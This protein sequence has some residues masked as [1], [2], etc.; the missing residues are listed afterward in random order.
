MNAMAILAVVWAWAIG[1]LIVAVLWPR[2]RNLRGDA[3]LILPLGALLGLA[4]SSVIFFFASRVFAAPGLVAGVAEAVLAVI[5]ALRL[6]RREPVMPAPTFGWR[7][8]WLHWITATIAV[9]MAVVAGILAMRSYQAEPYGGWDGWAI[10]NMHARMMFRGGPTWTRLLEASQLNWTHP[11]YPLLVSASVARVWAWAGA[12]S[13]FA[14]GLVSGVFAGATVALLV[15]AVAKVRQTLLGLIG[16]LLLLATPF[17]VTFSTNEHADIPLAAFMLATVVLAINADYDPK[18]IGL[19]VLAG[20]FAAAAAWTKNEGLLF[21]FVFAGVWVA[22]ELRRGSG[23]R[24]NSALFLAALGVGLVPVFYFKFFL[25]P[26]NDLLAGGDLFGRL[27]QVLD[28]GRHRMILSAL[29]RDGARFGEWHTVPYVAMA[30]PF[31]AWRC[32]RR[33][34]PRET[35]APLVLVLMLVGYYAVYLLTPQDLAWH[36]DSSLVRLLL[37]LWPIGLLCWGLTVPSIDLPDPAPRKWKT[38]VLTFTVV[39]A[40]AACAVVLALARQPAANELAFR[41]SGGAEIAVTPGLGWF[42]IERHERTVWVWSR[43][44]ATLHVHASAT[45]AVKPPALRFSLRSLAPRQVTIRVADRVV[46]QGSVNAQQFVPVEIRDL[47][48]ES[49]SID[50]EFMTD[51]DGTLESAA[52]DARRLAFAI[53]DLRIR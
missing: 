22:I 27:A 7:F 46:W 42:A 24:R 31:F 51:A 34:H 40:V 12:E 50:L 13:A 52:P 2:D 6:S 19:R 45:G 14:S 9:Q 29:W 3:L 8:H 33:L 16:G 15:A 36:L 49:E 21:A 39:N 26:P 18:H 37:Q 11:D 20:L 28:G 53:Y 35:I 10:W 5:L 47:T 43:G 4:T 41:R 48:F 44:N 23:S 38:P 32:R 30:L 25:A 17:F 1:I